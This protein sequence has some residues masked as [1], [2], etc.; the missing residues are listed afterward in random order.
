MDIINY[1]ILLF[2]ALLKLKIIKLK[3]VE[4]LFLLNWMNINNKI[5]LIDS[6]INIMY[7]LNRFFIYYS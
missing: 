2:S 5:I 7:L 1:L 4:K 6:Y 3:F